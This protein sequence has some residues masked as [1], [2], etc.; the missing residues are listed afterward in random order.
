MDVDCTQ[1]LYQY[2]CIDPWGGGDTCDGTDTVCT[3]WGNTHVATFDGNENDIYGNA[4]YILSQTSQDAID[5]FGKFLF[6]VHFG[7]RRPRFSVDYLRTCGNR[8]SS[9]DSRSEKG[10]FSS[11]DIKVTAASL[12]IHCG[13]DP[14]TDFGSKV[15]VKHSIA[16]MAVFNNAIFYWDFSFQWFVCGTQENHWLRKFREFHYSFLYFR[17]FFIC[18]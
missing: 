11:L 2:A 3:V 5:N 10:P 4:I 14:S 13:A 17:H 7:N 15:E 1:L 16:V 8:L 9:G 12:V 18:I 6:W